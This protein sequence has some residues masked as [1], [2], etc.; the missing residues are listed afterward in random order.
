LGVGVAVAE[1]F[2][3]GV[4]VIDGEPFC[5]GV[6]VD[7]FVAVAV[8]VAATVGT[9][10][11]VSVGRITGDAVAV[12]TT[13]SVGG[14]VGDGMKVV[15]VATG[16]EV[17]TGVNGTRLGFGVGLDGGSVGVAMTGVTVNGAIVGGL[18]SGVL[19]AAGVALGPSGIRVGNR[20]GGTIT[21]PGVA[22][23]KVT[24]VLVPI[25]RGVDSNPGK[26][27]VVAVAIGFSVG[28]ISVAVGDGSIT[29]GSVTRLTRGVRTGVGVSVA[30]INWLT[31]GAE[32]AVVLSSSEVS[33]PSPFDGSTKNA[34]RATAVRANAIPM[35]IGVSE[36][37]D[38]PVAC[39]RLDMPSFLACG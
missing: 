5:V 14:T 32:I 22:V 33:R 15:A 3:V 7:V 10:V 4:C 20:V 31:S 2:G 27:K 13:V 11:V 39:R 36:A 6:A 17:G 35:I 30:S 9:S 1:P 37:S 24:W 16:G 21:S 8:T 12:G 23:A 26:R 38:V 19:V 34:S 29:S 28:A 25:T 18:L